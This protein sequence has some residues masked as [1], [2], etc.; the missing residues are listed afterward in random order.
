M[1]SLG[2]GYFRTCVRNHGDWTSGLH[3]FWWTRRRLSSDPGIQVTDLRYQSAVSMRRQFE[4]ATWS[5]LMLR[6]QLLADVGRVAPRDDE[7]S[8]LSEVH[9]RAAEAVD[10]PDPASLAAWLQSEGEGLVARAM[11]RDRY[12]AMRLSLHRDEGDEADRG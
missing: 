7:M 2:R 1:L 3:I 8:M 10:T 9:E 12:H 4:L 5:M 6:L 11:P